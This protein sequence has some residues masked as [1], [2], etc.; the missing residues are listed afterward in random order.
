MKTQS[1]GTTDIRVTRLCYGAMRIAGGWVRDKV[2]A[3]AIE[4]DSWYRI[5]LAARGKK[6]D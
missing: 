4:R 5:L 6:L 1:L 2:D 3:A